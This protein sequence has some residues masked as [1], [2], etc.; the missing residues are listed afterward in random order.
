MAGSYDIQM[1]AALF[2][3]NLFFLYF[4]TC[5]AIINFNKYEEWQKV[6]LI[7]IVTLGSMLLLLRHINK[8]IMQHTALLGV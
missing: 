4:I 3:N 2:G 1:N 8:L 5:I 6:S 7:Y